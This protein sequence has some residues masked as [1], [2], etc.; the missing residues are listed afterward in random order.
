[1]VVPGCEALL[2]FL[3]NP[4]TYGIL[5]TSFLTAR[6]LYKISSL[7]FWP[8]FLRITVIYR[9]VMVT[10]SGLGTLKRTGLFAVLSVITVFYPTIQALYTGEI[11][12]LINLLTGLGT[13]LWN[14]LVLVVKNFVQGLGFLTEFFV[15]S[16]NVCGAQQNLD[17]LVKSLTEFWNVAAAYILAFRIDEAL[18]GKGMVR[19]IEWPEKYKTAAIVTLLS[20]TVYGG[21]I[22]FTALDQGS[23]LAQVL[24][25]RFIGL[26]GTEGVAQSG[27]EKAFNKNPG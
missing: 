5:G 4:L 25:D 8:N 3:K 11:T 18:W 16:K 2:P 7:T 9:T 24:A 17:L 22:V 27:V 12:G 1:M 13:D 10:I 15:S 6:Y 23:T 20:T 26:N 21:Q 19:E 14:N